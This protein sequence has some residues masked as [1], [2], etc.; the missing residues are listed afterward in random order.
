MAKNSTSEEPR[1]SPATTPIKSPHPDA[2]FLPSYES[3]K[4]W[5]WLLSGYY[6]A[7]VINNLLVTAAL[8]KT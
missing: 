1:T 2:E 5:A 4:V 8:R 7:I 6:L 3:S